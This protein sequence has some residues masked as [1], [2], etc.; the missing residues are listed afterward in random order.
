MTL[1]ITSHIGLISKKELTDIW[2]LKRVKQS[3]T[4]K[5]EQVKSVGECFIMF[6][7]FPA[8]HFI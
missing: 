7:M 8:E 1:Q 3:I 2:N 4:D 5:V 6:Y